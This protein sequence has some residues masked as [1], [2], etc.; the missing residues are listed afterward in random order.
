MQDDSE[1]AELLDAFIAQAADNMPEGALAVQNNVDRAEPA[2]ANTG[3]KA[4]TTTGITVL[5]TLDSRLTGNAGAEDTVFVFARAVEGPP[6]PLAVVRKQ[7]KDLPFR[8]T[9]DDSQ[10]MMPAMTL[11]RFPKVIIGARISK[12]GDATTQSG[13]LQGISDAVA[14]DTDEPVS[15]VIDQVVP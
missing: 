5:V 12:S 14:T 1:D 11:S 2:A 15:I 3:G 13:D 7:V 10:A 9:L 4:A 6:M 8:V